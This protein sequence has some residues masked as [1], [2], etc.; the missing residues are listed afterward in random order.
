MLTPAGSGMLAR[1][2]SAD[3]FI[4][5]PAQQDRIRSGERVAFIPI[6]EML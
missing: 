3:G 6:Q 5:I 1:L 2:A 4:V